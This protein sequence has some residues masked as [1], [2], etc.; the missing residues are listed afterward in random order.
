MAM[1]SLCELYRQLCIAHPAEATQNVCL[2][3]LALPLSRQEH[4]FQ[5]GHFRWA[6]HKL[7]CS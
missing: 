4:A 6:I 1:V 2:P 3:T 7:K 5:L